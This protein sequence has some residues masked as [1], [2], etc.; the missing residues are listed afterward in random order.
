MVWTVLGAEKDKVVFVSKSGTDGI[1]HQGSYLTILDGNKKFIV[2][3]DESSQYNPFSPS[4]LIVDMNLSPLLPDQKAVNVTS[5][6]RIIEYPERE[7]G[8]SSFIKPQLTA[9]RSNQEDLD[10]AIGNKEGIPIFPATAFA[11]NIQNLCDENGRFLQVRIP[12][13]TFFHQMLIAGR[14]GS[15]KTVA[16]KYMA[17]YFIEEMGGCVLAVNVKEEDLLT[18][19]KPSRT[20]NPKILKEWAD[21]GYTPRGLE[22]F[23]VYYPASQSIDYSKDVDFKKCERITLV[24]KHID[25]ETLTGLVQN[26]SDLGADHL[27]Q[28]FRYWKEEEMRENSNLTDFLNYLTVRNRE[29]TFPVKN[30]RGEELEPIRLFPGTY[31]NIYNALNYATNYFDIE[32]AKELEAADILQ[33]GKMSVIDVT[34]KG[35]FTFGSILLRDL[36]DKI[37]NAKSN[38]SLDTPI[39]IIIDEVHEFYNSSRS[40]EAL[41]LLDSICRKGRGLR[42]GIIFSSQN[43]EDIPKGISNVVNSK[44][45]FKSEL[46]SI[47]SLGTNVSGIDT[48]SFKQGYAVARIHGLSQLKFLKFP[49]S[50]AGVDDERRK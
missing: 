37:Y 49:M 48:E 15:G 18:M 11:R 6:T 9:K 25:P 12:E 35:G 38:K 16:M 43:P 24:T 20:K 13:D 28:I 41:Q 23:R 40:R 29:R 4:P 32:C 42:I 47:K 5:A 31:N 50:L 1:L 44:I 27:P 33:P 14:T 36:L 17:Q 8:M 2:R 10:M 22:T 26:L 46:S 39:L 34:G 3:V 21:L 7:D 19:D 45:Y 30:I